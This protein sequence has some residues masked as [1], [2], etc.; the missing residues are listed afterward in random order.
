MATAQKL[1]TI[2]NQWT[3]CADCNDPYPEWA[4]VSRGIIVCLDCSGV[5][6]GLGTHVSQ[7]R[8]LTLDVWQS[9]WVNQMQDS[10]ESFNEMYEYH[11]PS[12]YIKPT[13]TS[14]RDLRERYIVAKY[15]GADASSVDLKPLF[16]H[17]H[18]SNTDRDPLPPVF[19]DDDDDVGDDESTMEVTKNG[20]KS[21]R[22]YR[23]GRK[24]G[25]RH[26]SSSSGMIANTGVLHIKCIN[27][28]NLP[29]GNLSA[30]KS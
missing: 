2:V 3:S 5:H 8:S 19:D 28:I 21:W 22:N 25:G 24:S 26:R 9:E 12:S 17:T 23:D 20:T 29:K 1:Q 30:K 14:S 16:H 10:N 27:A 4:D 6:R 7:T 18:E 15:I 13:Q 11:V